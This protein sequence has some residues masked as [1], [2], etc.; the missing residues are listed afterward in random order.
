MRLIPTILIIVVSFASPVFAGQKPPKPA[1]LASKKEDNSEQAYII[2]SYR[3]AI[4][5][6]ADGTSTTEVTARYR[7]LSQAGVQ[8]LGLLAFSYNSANERLKIDYVRVLHSDGTV[9][10]TPLNSLQDMPADI[11]RQAPMYSDYR[12]KQAPVKGLSVGDLV[13]FQTETQV[14]HP[15][16]ANEFWYEYNFITALTVK[17]EELEV[18]VPTDKYVQIK[19]P[20]VKP[21]ITKEGGRTVYLW[22]HSNDKIPTASEQSNASPIPSVQITTFRSWQELGRWWDALETKAAAPTPDIRAKA[23]ELTKGLTTDQEKLNAIYRYVSS[24]FR[25]ISL[26]FGIGRY[27]PHTASEVLNNLYGD[28]KDKAT[29]LASLLEA[30]G[31]PSYPVLINSTRKIDPDMPS[32]GQFDHVI[33]VVPEGPNGENLVWLDST[34]EVAPVGFLAPI[35]RDKQALLIPQDGT[36][37][38]VKTP[39]DP[40]FACFQTFETDGKL[41][42][43]GTFTGKMHQVARNDYGFALRLLFFLATQSQWQQ[44]VQ[45]ISRLSG[46]GGDVSDVTAANPTDTDKPFQY[47]Y[48]Y[49]RKNYGDWA[50]HRIVSAITAIPLPN[51]ANA[52]STPIKPL[53]LGS[54]QEIT[55]KSSIQLP[56]SYTPTL[57]PAVNLSRDFADYHA[58]YSFK[59][60][61]FY[62][63]RQLIVKERE[64]PVAERADYQSFVKLVTND[65]NQFIPLT[66]ASAATPPDAQV[67]QLLQQARQAYTEQDFS[68][69]LDDAQRA[70]KLA[71]KSA[72]AWMMLG[73]LEINRNEPEDGETALRTAI[74]LAPKEPTAYTVLAMYLART[75]HTEEAIQ[76][77]RD[78]LKQVPDNVPAHAN[79]GWLL[80]NDKKYG[81]AVTELETI[82]KQNSQNKSFEIHLGMA[83]LGAG[84]TQEG[85]AALES[86]AKFDPTPFTLIAVAY[87]MAERN[88]DLASAQNYAQEAVAQVESASGQISLDKVQDSDIQ[89]I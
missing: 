23:A 36:P 6:R 26:S 34:E 25:Y 58:T 1:P 86:A 10:E 11:T 72:Y 18:S 79:L 85:I 14:L 84:K 42:S 43:D 80:L 7:A 22:K 16:I 2:E 63:E 75:G 17:Q 67:Q 69:A 46:Y 64:I 24:Q 8:Q 20:D 44:M 53:P 39:A 30:A 28:C 60:G 15:L 5:F 87:Q 71:P 61:V 47:T 3:T 57:P 78:L 38:L 27:E 45:G 37:R 54:P 62:A 19:A 73:G 68:D 12:Q 40:P 50:N 35:L 31:I 29:L 59:A 33:S 83:A 65:E 76:V 52:E 81:D 74:S 13:E 88:V 56:A 32:P 4:N 21:V 51:W 82:A 89:L 48:D 55:L 66:T 77:W 70:V 49:T 9:V 41:S